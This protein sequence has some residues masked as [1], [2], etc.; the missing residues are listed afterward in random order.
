MNRKLI[1]LR[2]VNVYRRP[3]ELLE[4]ATILVRDDAIVAAGKHASVPIPHDAQTLD[5]SGR[6]I[7]PGFWNSH[8]HFFERKWADAGQIPSPELQRQL[9]DMINRFGFTHVFDL[10]SDWENTRVLRRRIETGEVAGPAILSTGEGLVSAGSLPGDH[11]YRMMGVEKIVMPEIENAEQAVTAASK[12]LKKGADGIKLYLQGAPSGDSF[13]ET[14]IRAVV[15]IAHD[16]GKPVFAHPTN[17]EDVLKAIR[18]GVD[19]V[20]HTTPHSGPWDQT[21]VTEAAE[22]GTA[23]TPTLSLWKYFARHDRQSVQDRVLDIAATQVRDWISA[24]AEVLF[25]TDLGAAEYD[26]AEEF[27]LMEEAGMDFRAILTSLTAAPARRFGDPSRHG[28]IA[29]GFKADFTYLSSRESAR[30]AS[31]LP[32]V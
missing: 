4:D 6:F 7:A 23:L 16:Q 12:L 26:P 13:P 24:G 11:V 29:A 9:D 22:R 14:L 30:S 3:D 10:S 25:G 20:A 2:G 5:L 1:A 17:G 8:V 21:L 31:I 15:D 28:E 27:A 19:V 18:A 32:P